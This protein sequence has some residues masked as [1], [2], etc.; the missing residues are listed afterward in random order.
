MNM[1]FHLLSAKSLLDSTALI[2]KQVERINRTTGA[3]YNVFE[4]L[5]L[6]THENSH[7]LFIAD[8]LDPNGSHGQ[9][10]L[11]LEAFKS[12]LADVEQTQGGTKLSD[13][14]S[15]L[16]S[17]DLAVF[18]ELHLGSK[19]ATS[20]GRISKTKFMRACRNDN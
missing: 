4:I 6:S 1:D 8:L 2:R 3:Q 17:E 10:E 13:C 12:E 11:F 20:G 16:S 5:R 15:S 14:F 7:S 9:G 19:T 18:T